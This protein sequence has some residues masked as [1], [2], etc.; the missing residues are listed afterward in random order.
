VPEARPLQ[1]STPWPRV[2]R[3]TAGISAEGSEPAADQE[4]RS[5]AALPIGELVRAQLDFVWRLLRRLG[6]SPAR[7]DDL[8]QEVFF[9][10]RCAAE[11]R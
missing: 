9:W 6:H 1:L 2:G 10:W 3:V 5:V 8:S 11:R 7:A 4:L